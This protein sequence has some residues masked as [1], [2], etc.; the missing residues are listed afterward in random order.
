MRIAFSPKKRRPGCPLV[1]IA[2]GGDVPP[3]DF[4]KFFPHEVWLLSPTDDMG[5]YPVDEEH[6]LKT[7]AAIAIEAAIAQGVPV[8]ACSQLIVAKAVEEAK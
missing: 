3:D 5:A 6:S 7:L 8:T 4:A 2:F 1:Q